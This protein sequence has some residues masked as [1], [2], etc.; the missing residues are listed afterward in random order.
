MSTLGGVVMARHVSVLLNAR[1]TR[2]DVGGSVDQ[3]EPVTQAQSRDCTEVV[4][5]APR[6]R[7]IGVPVTV[8][9]EERLLDAVSHVVDSH[10][11]TVFVG[12]YAALYRTLE[13]QPNYRDLVTRS[14]TYPDG[15]G[16]VKELHKRG[17]DEAQRLATTDVVHPIC[18]LAAARGWRVGLYGAAPGVAERA[19]QALAVSA[20]GVQVSAVW[21]GY[22]GGPS[23]EEL[24]A[25]NLDILFVALG[26]PRQ[27]AWAHDTAVRAGVPAVLT[28]G[29]L[30]DFL[31]GDKRRAPRWM[32]RAGLEWV[33]RIL[34]EPRRLLGRYLLGNSHFLR[35]ARTD[36]VRLARRNPDL[37]TDAGA[38]V[39]GPAVEQLVSA[40]DSE[41]VRGGVA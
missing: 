29:G 25:A 32:Q 26:A 24:R 37:L 7:L 10:A 38:P 14:V 12:L 15:A 13:Q 11:P 6:A 31:S 8:V 18:R 21:D 19:A 9:T 33:F 36:R 22:S 23:V 2:R 28:C 5:G 35:Q 39:R 30:L 27:E 1:E 4:L 40:A 16:V 41:F 17:V 34:L 20:A 3:V